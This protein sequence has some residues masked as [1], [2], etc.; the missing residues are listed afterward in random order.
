MMYC[1]HCDSDPCHCDEF[2]DQLHGEA[3]LLDA[4][5]PPNIAHHALYHSYIRAVHGFLGAGI[6]NIIPDLDGAYMC[7]MDGPAMGD[8]D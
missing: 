8:S 1:S 2:R 5:I 6:R 4:D 7:H 3:S